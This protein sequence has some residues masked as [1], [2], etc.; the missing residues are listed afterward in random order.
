[1]TAIPIDGGPVKAHDFTQ[2]SLDGGKSPRH[3]WARFSA[4]A[5]ISPYS[6]SVNGGLSSA[7]RVR[8]ATVANYFATS[9]PTISSIINSNNNK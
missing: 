2:S 4:P 1:M 5:S 6:I 9:N 7:D 3:S 8:A